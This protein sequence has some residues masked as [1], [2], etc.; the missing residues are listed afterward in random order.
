MSN[1]KIAMVAHCLAVGFILAIA[2][3]TPTKTLVGAAAQVVA[4]IA[5]PEVQ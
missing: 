1:P 3:R 4:P 5:S 2:F